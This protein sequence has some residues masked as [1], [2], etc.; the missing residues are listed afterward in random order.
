MH[1]HIDALH[2]VTEEVSCLV[3]ARVGAG[4]T[5]LKPIQ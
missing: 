3:M 2:I 4:I 1:A 5:P